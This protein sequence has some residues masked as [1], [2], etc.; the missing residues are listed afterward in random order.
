M[1]VAIGDITED[2][3]V[4]LRDG[5]DMERVRAMV[6]FEEEGGVLP[7]LIT[8]GDNHLLADG[9]HRLE[10]GRVSGRAEMEVDNRPGGKAEAIVLAIQGN[11]TKLSVPLT[12]SQRN[13]GVKLLLLEGWT[14]RAI[15]DAIAAHKSTIGNIHTVMTAR[16][17]LANIR[18]KRQG[19]R[20]VPVAV[21]PQPV[22]SRL[23]D[24]VIL[25]IASLPL[26]QQTPFAAAVV[27]VEKDTGS[28]LSEPRVREA[29]QA[30][31]AA[32]QRDPADVVAEH[33]PSTWPKK[34]PRSLPQLAE[35]V[36]KTLDE[37][38]T[39]EYS[40]DGKKVHIDALLRMLAD[41][42]PRIPLEAQTLRH[43]FAELT[44]WADLYATR[45]APVIEGEIVEGEL[46]EVSA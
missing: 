12:R 46:M 39:R 25:R 17:L 36:V 24:T 3:D 5:L 15:G 45:F 37:L 41:E 20:P 42:S 30:L 6:E 27:Q 40:I 43:R 23:D 7:A 35:M 44:V 21:L 14:Q 19:P 34:A 31:K 4:Q 13:A 11:D 1:K 16:G 32:P 29:V 22:H 28:P 26:A 9:H 10:A 2:V 38:R 18:Q 8:V 33:A